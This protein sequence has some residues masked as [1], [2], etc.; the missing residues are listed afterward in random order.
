[1]EHAED[2]ISR[3]LICTLGKDVMY[4]TVRIGSLGENKFSFTYFFAAAALCLIMT[5]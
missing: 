2:C 1:M 5:L 3:N 4:D